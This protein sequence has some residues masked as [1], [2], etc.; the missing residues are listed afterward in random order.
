MLLETVSIRPL[1]LAGIYLL[2]VNPARPSHDPVSRMREQ[3]Q[4]LHPPCSLPARRRGRACWYRAPARPRHRPGNKRV[5]GTAR[6]QGR[7]Q[8]VGAMRAPDLRLPEDCCCQT[9]V[10]RRVPLGCGQRRAA[11]W[12]RHEGS[13]VGRASQ[14]VCATPPKAAQQ[15]IHSTSSH[16]IQWYRCAVDYRRPSW[17]LSRTA[18]VVGAVAMLGGRP[19]AWL[20]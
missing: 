20:V 8:P 4:H 15:S 6:P 2:Q 9:A 17:R 10:W 7:S 13:A 19:A 18:R 12:V 1:C 5:R 14:C 3:W 11:R 16:W